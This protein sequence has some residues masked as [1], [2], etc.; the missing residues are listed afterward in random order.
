ME[1][2]CAHAV[3]LVDEGDAGDI[4]LGRLTPDGLGLGL[5]PR[6]G[7]EDRNGSVEHTQGALDLCG[8]VNVAR[9]VDD[10]DD[11]ILPET[12]GGGRRDGHATLL[13]LDHPVHGCCPI[14]DLTYL[15]GLSSVVEDALRRGSLARIDMGH[16][17]DITEVLEVVLDLS[18]VSLLLMFG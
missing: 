14:V 18:H 13:L 8:E 12:G 10:L 7:V 15:V 6:D 11:M 17:A 2:V 3:V 16:D 9:R 1:E 5:N 4:V